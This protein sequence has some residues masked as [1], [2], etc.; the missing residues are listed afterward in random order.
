MHFTSNPCS[1]GEALFEANVHLRR[2]TSQPE[3]VQVPQQVRKP[4][5]AKQ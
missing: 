3:T 1:L 5:C 4:G 2:H